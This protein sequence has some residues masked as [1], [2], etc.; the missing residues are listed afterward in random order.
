MPKTDR[1]GT[2]EKD[3]D[4]RRFIQAMATAALAGGLAGQAVRSEEEPEPRVQPAKSGRMKVGCQRWGSDP[5]RLGFLL[6]YGVEGICISPARSGPEGVWT[7]ET[8]RAAK[9]AVEDAGLIPVSMYWGVPQDVLI[10]ERRDAPIARCKQ[11]IAAAGKAGIPCLAYTLHVR[12]WRART[13]STPGRGG[14]GY[15]VWDLEQ[16]ERQQGKRDIGP[17]SAEE[18]WARVTHFLQQVVPVATEARVRLACHPDDPPMPQDNQWKIAQVLDSVEGLKRFVSTAES[19]FHGLTFCQGCVWEMLPEKDKE[20][21]YEAIR[22]FG[23]RKK[24]FQVHFRNLRGGPKKFAETFPDDG[25]IDMFR[26]VRT[27]KEVGY[28]GVL[29]PDHVPGHPEDATDSPHFA[30]AYG[31]IKGLIDAAYS[32]G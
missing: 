6:R 3:L 8:C 5:K 18:H 4:R 32:A 10:P 17:L 24:I 14:A 11:Q 1:P 29:M 2:H 7:E 21:L 13:G 31:Y 25:D 19:P 27:Y 26:A 22:W 28:D 12:V 23:S 30:F 15:S 20:G 9:K 16:A